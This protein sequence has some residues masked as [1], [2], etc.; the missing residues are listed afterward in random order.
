MIQPAAHERTGSAADLHAALL[1]ALGIERAGGE[2]GW[3]QFGAIG[4]L[5]LERVTAPTLLVQGKVDTDVTP[6]H[7]DRAA[8]AIPIAELLR[9]D[10]GTH[11]AFW[12]RTE[13]TAAQA[14]ALSVLRG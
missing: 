6:D 10:G 2:A 7:S 11:L 9:L 8:A 14:R 12:T 5:E 1:D 4:S 13:A 3:A